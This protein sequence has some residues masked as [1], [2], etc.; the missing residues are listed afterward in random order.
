LT[1]ESRSIERQVPNQER[2]SGTGGWPAVWA[3]FAGGLVA[4]AYIGKVPPALPALREALG[5]SLLE[6]GF[7][8]TAFNVLGGLAGMLVGMLC[9]RHGHKRLGVLGLWIM[10]AGGL[11][12]AGADGFPL[13]LA[14]RFVEGAGFIL[15]T[16]SAPALLSAAMVAPAARAKAFGLWGAYMPSGG[17]LALLAAPLVITAFG[18]RGLWGLLAAAALASAGLVARAVPAAPT[19]GLGSLR[20]ARESLSQ[21]G[22]IALAL[23]FAFYVAQWTSV[24]LW[25][26]TFLLDERGV[27]PATAALLTALMVLANVPGNL[28]GGWLLAHGARRG[29]LIVSAC[30]I[31]AL[32][33][34]GM[35]GSGLPDALRFLLVLVFSGCI[36]V[37]PS[38]IFSGVPV[39][40][41]SARHVG[42]TNGMVMQASQIGQFFGPIAIAWLA[43]RL[44]GWS[45]SLWAMLA[46]AACGAAC[47]AALSAIEKRRAP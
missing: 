47:G 28:G 29:P 13:L 11:L 2:E 35:L 7:V 14:A 45:A 5:L 16:V 18:W 24:M 20:L 36:G 46:F 1:H 21:P 22:S 34:M 19:G 40:A 38:A 25:L 42:T 15:F 9:D 26:P 17:C 27:A 44:G 31:A 39:H 23:L 8:A 4:G 3:L 37:V 10:A 43:S 6:S 30:A 32:C 41:K 12:G 33:S